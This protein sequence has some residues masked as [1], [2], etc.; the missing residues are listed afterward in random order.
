M[1]VLCVSFSW[2]GLSVRCGLENTVFQEHNTFVYVNDLINLAL[3]TAHICC[4]RSIW[5]R[6]RAWQIITSRLDGGGCQLV[7][8]FYPPVRLIDWFHGVYRL[9]REVFTH[10]DI[11][12]FR[13]KKCKYESCVWCIRDIF[14]NLLWDEFWFCVCILNLFI[15]YPENNSCR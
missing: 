2:C 5:W 10:L 11:S 1:V 7:S 9:T 12:Q 6:E 4:R 3:Y 15:L 14:L 13:P 8:W